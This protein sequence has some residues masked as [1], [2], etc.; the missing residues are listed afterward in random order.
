[1]FKSQLKES[2]VYMQNLRREIEIHAWLNHPHIIQFYGYFWDKKKVYFI[3]EWAE[4]GDLFTLLKK[5]KYGFPEDK[6]AKYMKQV[7]EALHYM[8]GKNIIHWDIKPENILVD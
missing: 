5:T 3:L 6:V 4:E 2:Q 8:H 1:M 7:M